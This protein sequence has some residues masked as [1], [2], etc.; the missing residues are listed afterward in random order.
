MAL[1]SHSACLLAGL[2][3]E[4]LHKSNPLR[5]EYSYGLR[6][7]SAVQWPA[8]AVHKSNLFPNQR[9]AGR[10]LSALRNFWSF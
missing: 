7:S 3:T 8:P 1:S 5:S 9:Q 6:G 10:A 2:R 4:E